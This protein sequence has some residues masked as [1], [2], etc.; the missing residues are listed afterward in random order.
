[1]IQPAKRLSKL[2][3]EPLV[4]RCFD[5]IENLEDVLEQRCCVLSDQM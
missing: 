4:N 1:M 3:D 5:T 2:V